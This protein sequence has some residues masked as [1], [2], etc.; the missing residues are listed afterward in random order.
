MLLVDDNAADRA[1]F[2][3]LLQSTK[4]N[5]RFH[6]FEAESGLAAQQ[7]L[8]KEKFD[9]VLLDYLLPDML[10]EELLKQ[11]TGSP[12]LS[13]LPVIMLSG[14]SEESVAN[15]AVQSGARAYLSKNDICP[16]SLELTICQALLPAMESTQPA[17]TKPA[18]S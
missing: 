12:H 17:G 8:R 4:S 18:Y 16:E 2:R 15:L 6:F 9:C 3:Y 7:L 5:S 11:I 10:G 13:K 1:L 14:F